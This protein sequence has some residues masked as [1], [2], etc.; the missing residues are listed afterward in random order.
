M[1][2]AYC[3]ILGCVY[4]S[5]ITPTWSGLKLPEWDKFQL[6]FV[7]HVFISISGS[8]YWKM[9]ERVECISIPHFY[10]THESYQ[11]GSLLIYGSTR[12]NGSHLNRLFHLVWLKLNRPLCMSDI[13]RLSLQVLVILSWGFCGWYTTVKV[14][15]CNYHFNNAILIIEKSFKSK[16]GAILIKY[17]RHRSWRGSRRTISTFTVKRNCFALYT[18]Y[19]RHLGKQ[20]G[21]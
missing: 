21:K 10:V 2:I 6:S 15:A 1:L 3:L 20:G 7:R 18:L 11:A 17:Y 4:M 12:M 16:I 19:I 8:V 5:R 13:L 14:T 9:L